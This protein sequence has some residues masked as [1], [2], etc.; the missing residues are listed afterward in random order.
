VLFARVV[1]PEKPLVCEG[2]RACVPQC[3]QILPL[4]FEIGADNKAVSAQNA[5]VQYEDLRKARAEHVAR[6]SR[7]IGMMGQWENPLAIWLRDRI[8]PLMMRFMDTEKQNAWMCQP[9]L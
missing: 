3:E 2:H 7:Q 9:Q 8:M 6:E 4:E 1:Q 5:F